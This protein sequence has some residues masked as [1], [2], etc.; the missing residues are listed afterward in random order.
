MA[1]MRVNLKAFRDFV[2]RGDAEI[3]T[4]DQDQAEKA[5]EYFKEVERATIC[6]WALCG[7]IISRVYSGTASVLTAVTMKGHEDLSDKFTHYM[8]SANRFFI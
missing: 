2:W 8:T 3:K 5:K 7:D 6:M 4:E 1:K